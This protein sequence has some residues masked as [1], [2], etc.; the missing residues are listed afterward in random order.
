[1]DEV[2]KKVTKKDILLAAL[3]GHG[4]QFKAGDKEDAFFC[5]RDA[6][7]GKAETLVSLSWLFKELDDRGGKANLVLVDACRNDPDPARAGASTAARRWRSPRGR[8][9]SSVARG[10]RSYETEK[11]G[12]GHG[13]FFHFVLEGL[14]GKAARERHGAPLP[15]T[16]WRPT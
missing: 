5:P 4:V 14:R 6:V 7:L 1:M 13:V 3:A 11:A 15:G 2:L 8:R 10:Q 9:S 16:G 12:E